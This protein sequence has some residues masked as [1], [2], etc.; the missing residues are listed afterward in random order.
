VGTSEIRPGPGT[1]QR[2]T[3]RGQAVFL[4]RD[5]VLNKALVRDNVSYPPAALD[6]VELMPGAVEMAARLRELGF[7]LLVVTNQPDVARGSQQKERVAEINDYLIKRLG[8]HAV[9]TCYHDSADGCDCRKPRPGLLLQA[10][11]EWPI[12]LENSF[13]VGDRYNDVEAGRQAGCITFLF[14]QGYAGRPTVEPDYRVVSLTEVVNII[15][16]LM[17]KEE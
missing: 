12:T 3:D 1:G 16:G 10:A 9:Y 6:Q 4:D 11:R 2:N 5:G 13:M 8:L 15:T 14:D 17:Q 7:Y